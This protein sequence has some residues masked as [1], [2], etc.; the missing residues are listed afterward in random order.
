MSFEQ[1]D[2]LGESE[3]HALL[4]KMGEIQ[5]SLDSMSQKLDEVTNEFIDKN[6]EENKEKQ[7]KGELK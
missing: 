5:K 3:I 2:A 6:E 1:K 7:T 4:K